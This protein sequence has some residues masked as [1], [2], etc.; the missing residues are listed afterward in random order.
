MAFLTDLESGEA[1]V[2]CRPAGCCCASLAG[3][4]AFLMH[5]STMMGS[6]RI[7]WQDAVIIR[8]WYMVALLPPSV[9]HKKASH[10]LAFFCL[11]FLVKMSKSL[12]V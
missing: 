6:S 11:R 8:R 7:A 3:L 4:R 10:W 5:V 2:A 9:D 12:S 1:Y